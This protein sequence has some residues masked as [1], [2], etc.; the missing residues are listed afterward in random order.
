MILC[1]L[2]FLAC[3]K[4][5]PL[6]PL[7]PL[8]GTY[9]WVYR[10]SR[11]TE[12]TFNSRHLSSPP[13][14]VLIGRDSLLTYSVGS[15]NAKFNPEMQQAQS[16]IWSNGPDGLYM[17]GAKFFGA[18]M[19]LESPVLHFKYPASEGESWV[20]PV[21]SY[22]EGTLALYQPGMMHITVEDVDFNYSFATGSC[23]C[24]VYRVAFDF[25]P[26]EG[27]ADEYRMIFKPGLGL[28]RQEGIRSSDGAVISE[29][30][31]VSYSRNDRNTRLPD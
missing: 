18:E 29:M 15:V 25:D 31:L 24:M 5:E 8:D 9:S 2:V 12:P 14:K 11:S 4:D 1:C 27:E 16:W 21:L 30:T 28:V 6:E 7:M 23:K 17:H 19:L 22:A 20:V 3:D 13:F 10:A 26:G